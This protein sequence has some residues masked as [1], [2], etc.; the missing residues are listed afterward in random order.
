MPSTFVRQRL[1]YDEARLTFAAAWT[2][3]SCSRVSVSQ[4][5]DSQPKR[6][7][8]TSP[9]TTRAVLGR[10]PQSRMRLAACSSDAARTSAVTAR[11]ASA[12][13][14]TRRLPSVPVAPVTRMVPQPASRFGG[15]NL[16]HVGNDVRC[17]SR[18]RRA[19]NLAARC[20]AAGRPLGENGLGREWHGLVLGGGARLEK[21]QRVGAERDHVVLRPDL[22]SKSATEHSAELA[23]DVVDLGTRRDVWAGD[24]PQCGV[25]DLAGREAWNQS[26]VLERR[27][28]HPRG[29]G[30]VQSLPDG[31]QRSTVAEDH[32]CFQRALRIDSDVENVL[33]GSQLCLDL[34]GLDAYPGYLHLACRADQASSRLLRLAVRERGPRSG[35]SVGLRVPRIACG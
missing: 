23:D 5:G 33:V 25:V 3:A 13:S 15:A 21:R 11:P 9:A 29:D 32:D 12:R 20:D 22:S 27:G 1:A 30:R 4:R 26:N 14:A 8:S 2:T 17:K 19:T 6:S 18:G 7:A 35:R 34:L 31:V 24:R 28:H 16:P 10:T